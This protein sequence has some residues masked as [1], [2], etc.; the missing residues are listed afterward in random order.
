MVPLGGVGGPAGGAGGEG[1]A[2]SGVRGTGAWFGAG[3]TGASLTDSELG[4]WAKSGSSVRDGCERGASLTGFGLRI[5]AARASAPEVD[6][7]PVDKTSKS[8]L[9]LVSPPSEFSAE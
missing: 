5:G 6:V 1:G 4:A 8:A 2:L 9:I 3:A 7:N